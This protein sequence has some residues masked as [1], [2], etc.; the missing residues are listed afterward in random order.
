MREKEVRGKVYLLI[1]RGRCVI[2]LDQLYARLR[3]SLRTYVGAWLMSW[4]IESPKFLIP[5]KIARPP[6]YFAMPDIRS[7]FP[8]NF[9]RL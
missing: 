2:F 5:Q 6:A 8:P 1:A 4:Q 3:V 7:Y 9:H